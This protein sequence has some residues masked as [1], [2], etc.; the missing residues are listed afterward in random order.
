M[1]RRT[2]DQIRL[3]GALAASLLLACGGATTREQTVRA[4]SFPSGSL[5]IDHAMHKLIMEELGSPDLWQLPGSAPFGVI[6]G[7]EAQTFQGFVVEVIL[8]N[9]YIS[10]PCESSSHRRIIAWRQLAEGSGVEIISTWEPMAAPGHAAFPLGRDSTCALRQQAATAMLRSIV[11]TMYFPPLYR[12][13][14]GSVS[15]QSSGLE[16]GKPCAEPAS[17]M[18]QWSNGNT[19]VK[20]TFTATM[21]ATM[22]R[23]GDSGSG[24][25]P[26]N[27]TVQFGS[28]LPGIRL[29]IDCLTRTFLQL[30]CPT[31]WSNVPTRSPS[32]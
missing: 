1:T 19:C 2:T 31:D 8:K 20:L 22:T 27:K 24:Q 11:D 9:E 23:R 26:P 28:R 4:Y 13:T 32:R 25:F 7:G 14:G 29:E 18:W 6:N 30:Q 3:V 15:V 5:P 12:A 17:G 10:K 21:S 16:R